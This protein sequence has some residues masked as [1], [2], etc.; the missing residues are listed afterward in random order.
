M[1]K[2]AT[3]IKLDRAALL[4]RR[5]HPFICT[6]LE[7][8]DVGLAVVVPGEVEVRHLVLRREVRRVARVVRPDRKNNMLTGERFQLSELGK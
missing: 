1:N 5:H 2:T 3:K 4:H 8:G 6:D 7:H